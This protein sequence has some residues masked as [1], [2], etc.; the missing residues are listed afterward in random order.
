VRP[1]ADETKSLETKAKYKGGIVFPFK[2]GDDTD[3]WVILSCIPELAVVFETKVRA[4][5]R[6]VFEVC[7]LSE[8]K[9][10]LSP[11]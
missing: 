9:R 10:M 1:K 2:Q 8:L 3:P 11:N 5:Y 6:A 4:P 7:K